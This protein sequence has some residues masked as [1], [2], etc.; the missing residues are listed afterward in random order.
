MLVL[1]EYNEMEEWEAYHKRKADEL[2]SKVAILEEKSLR[3]AAN[4]SKQQ[5]ELGK[6]GTTQSHITPNPN[7]NTHN[8][9]N[10]NAQ[11]TSHNKK[12]K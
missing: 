6:V 3:D 10:S 1:N 9:N 5:A 7:T 8:S 2:S 4:P 11:H 12:G